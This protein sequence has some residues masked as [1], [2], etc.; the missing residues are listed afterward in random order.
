MSDNLTYDENFH[1]DLPKLEENNFW[2]VSRNKRI[3][4]IFEKYIKDDFD[5]FLEIGCGTG[6]VVKMLAKK[7][8]YIKIYASEYLLSGLYQAKIRLKNYNNV[9]FLQLDA[10]K[11][12]SKNMYSAIG[13]FDVIEHITEEDDVL[14]EIYDSLK[15][16]GK[17]I[18]SVPQHK[19]LWSIYDDLGFHKRRYT[20]K[21]LKRK[22]EENNFEIIYINS[23]NSLLF[24]LMYISRFLNKF[25]KKEHFDIMDELKISKLTNNILMKILNL[26]NFLNN[27]GINFPFG[28]SLIG[29]AKKRA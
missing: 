12:E 27:I 1:K 11:M 14:K 6:F 23:F 3:E 2:F 28:G 25:K 19:F 29:V 20:R 10:R 7:F 26:E 22:L 15:K 21:Y 9:S 13:A 17:F 5:N 16:D 4:H 24:P 8:P 18:F